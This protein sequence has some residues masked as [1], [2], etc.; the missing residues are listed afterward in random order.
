MASRRSF[1]SSIRTRAIKAFDEPAVQKALSPAIHAAI[2]LRKAGT[3]ADRRTVLEKSRADMDAHA[4]GMLQELAKTVGCGFQKKQDCNPCLR[5][6]KIAET[7]LKEVEGRV[8][9]KAP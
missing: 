6:D 1:K 9:P 7:V 5:K 8:K 2:A 4:L 3:C